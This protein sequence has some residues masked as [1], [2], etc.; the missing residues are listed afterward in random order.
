MGTDD[1]VAAIATPAGQGGIAVI[2]ISG[3]DALNV[4]RRV[5]THRGP[6]RSRTLYYGHVTDPDGD[7][8]DEAMAVFMKGPK[9]YT[10]E[11]V[12]EI[13]CHGGSVAAGRVLDAVLRAGARP[14]QPGEF[15]KRA[16][17]SGRI[18]LAQAEAVMLLIGAR[19]EAAARAGLRQLG[20]GVSAGIRKITGEL[21]GLIALIEAA[22]DYPDEIDEEAGTAEVL[23]RLAPIRSEL[24]RM[25]DR[26]GARIVTGGYSVALIGSPNVGKS[27]LMNRL[28]G[29]QRAIVTEIPG[30]TRDIVTG[31]MEIGGIDVEISDTAG[32]RESGDPVERIGVERAR[33]AAEQADLVLFVLDGTK[34]Y[35][36]EEQALI[37]DADERWVICR[38]KS[39]LPQECDIVLPEGKGLTVL[40]VSAQ[41]GEGIDRLREEIRKRACGSEPLLVTER[42]LDAVKRAAESLDAAEER[43]KEGWPLDLCSQDLAEALRSLN[44]ITG[45]DASEQVID[46]VFSD[47]CVGK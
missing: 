8:L 41:T 39:D 15:T 3:A 19:S 17:L 27:S 24:K 12:A 40:T 45:E 37:S 44:E 29:S 26:R 38:N 22:D 21:T 28:L 10:R 30:T 16:F 13:Q 46:R 23:A 6:Y 31:H 9:T 32:L 36:P 14:A 42:H 47:F 2:R 20:G 33:T 5:F 34:E 25:C 4:L 43:L 18:D 7:I 35:V 11:D 1:T